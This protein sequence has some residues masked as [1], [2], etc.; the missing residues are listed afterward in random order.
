MESTKGHKDAF[1]SSENEAYLC[2][3]AFIEAFSTLPYFKRSEDILGGCVFFV[4]AWRTQ[5]GDG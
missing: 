2:V 4:S 3:P 5:G 1:S